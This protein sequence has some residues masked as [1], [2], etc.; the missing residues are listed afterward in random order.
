MPTRQVFVDTS[1]W[2]AVIDESDNHHAEAVEIYKQLLNS[3]TRLITS[4]LII[5]ETQIW[6]R[7]RMNPE[8]AQTFLRN[9]NH[10][11]RV[12]IL[13]P[14]ANAEKQAKKIL[15]QFSDHDFSLA[16]AISFVIMKTAGVK[17][18]FSYDSHFATAGFITLS[19]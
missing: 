17:E 2:L 4:I 8:S 9:V 10:S 19:N 11:P 1:A 14:D 5:A 3:Q 16:D 18:A 15:E 13:Y 7:R 6:L 12:D